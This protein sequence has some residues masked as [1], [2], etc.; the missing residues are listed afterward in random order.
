MASNK[1]F[2]LANPDKVPSIDILKNAVAGGTNKCAHSL[3][4]E[5]ILIDSKWIEVIDKYIFNLENVCRHAQTFIVD[6]ELVENIERVKKINAKSIRH[7]SQNTKYIA[8]VEDDGSVMPKKLL[9]TTMDDNLAIYENRF[10]RTLIDRLGK[11]IEDR[12]RM[13]VGLVK[14]KDT[15]DLSIVS[16]SKIRKTFI[17]IESHVSVTEPSRNKV[18]LDKNVDLLGILTRLRQRVTILKSTPFYKTLAQSKPVFPPIMKTNLLTKNV[19]YSACYKLWVYISG[20]RMEGFFSEHSRKNLPVDQE[21]FDDMAEVLAMNIQTLFANDYIRKNDFMSIADKKFKPKRYQV[22]NDFVKQ[23]KFKGEKPED[24]PDIINQY[25]FDQIKQLI[26]DTVKTETTNTVEP[27]SE[28]NVTFPKFYRALAK[29]NRSIYLN[30][31]QIEEPV[32]PVPRNKND[33]I[34]K[35]KQELKQ[36]QEELKRFH[37][38]NKLASDELK[39]TLKLESKQLVKCE[40]LKFDI[41]LLEDNEIIKD[42]SKRGK[43]VKKKPVKKASKANKVVEKAETKLKEQSDALEWKLVE[44]EKARQEEIIRLKHEQYLKRKEAYERRMIEKLREKY[45]EEFE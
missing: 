36:E 14:T 42:P 25:Y 34:K 16:K 40:K 7:L 35:K 44:E 1:E 20:Y 38:L 39:T 26:S 41:E 12:Y 24:F 13:L 17:T 33:K 43:D 31:L 4:T 10:V 21:Y 5:A 29:I 28:L 9:T 6:N 19:D 23:L 45:P 2:I 22:V 15:T 11:F 37:L 30:V 32:T 18:L 8:K 3:V 27:K